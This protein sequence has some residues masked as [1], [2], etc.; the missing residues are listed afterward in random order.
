MVAK[1]RN[2]WAMTRYWDKQNTYP[3]YA[4]ACV[5]GGLCDLIYLCFFFPIFILHV[6]VINYRFIFDLYLHL[7][8]IYLL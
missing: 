3:A 2:K 6:H 8:K 7:Y 1:K 5:Y 4:C